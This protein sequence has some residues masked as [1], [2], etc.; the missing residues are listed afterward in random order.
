MRNGQFDESVKR[1]LMAASK[2]A[3]SAE[4][5]SYTHLDVYKRQRFI[6]SDLD[7]VY[8]YM[9]DVDMAT[10]RINKDVA[11]LVKSRVAPVSYTHLDV[12]KRQGLAIYGCQPPFCLL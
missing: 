5:V 7:K 2:E 11:M 1:A 9:S 4:A 6:I 10:T 3:E 12:Y 8:A